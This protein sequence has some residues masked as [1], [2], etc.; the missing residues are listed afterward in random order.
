MGFEHGAKTTSSATEH[1]AVA[2]SVSNDGLSST[3][4]SGDDSYTIVNKRNIHGSEADN[5]DTVSSSDNIHRI[6]LARRKRV[7]PNYKNNLSIKS[8]DSSTSSS[9]IKSTS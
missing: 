4:S 7:N 5:S 6:K 3:G 8:T 1:G 2:R 9:S